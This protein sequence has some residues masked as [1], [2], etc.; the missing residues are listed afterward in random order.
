MNNWQKI[1]D[2]RKDN[3]ANVDMENFREVFTELKRIDG[4]DS[5]ELTSTLITLPTR[6]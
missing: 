6:D 3:F 1:W 2:A 5:A 4:F